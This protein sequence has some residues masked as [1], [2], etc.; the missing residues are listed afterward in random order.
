MVCKINIVM[1]KGLNDHIIPDI[2]A[3]VKEAG[4]D[5]CNIM[6]LIPVKGTV[7]EHL[8]MV[9][10]TEIMETR[11][12]CE[13]VLPQMYHCRQCRADAIGT[14][15]EDI[16]YQFTGGNK[17][18]AIVE[19]RSGDGNTGGRLLFAVASK[20]GIAVDQHF[21]HVTAFHI[22]RYENGKVEFIEK[23]EVSQY[24]QG[25]QDCGISAGNAA[26]QRHEDILN[27]IIETVTGC[28]GVIAL[29]IGDEPLRR[30]REKGIQFYTTYTYAAEAVKE[31]AEKLIAEKERPK[32][33]V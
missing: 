12:K 15:D 7:F 22:Y 11:K 25:K 17:P 10:N 21:G 2:A 3:K 8:P 27:S 6:Q 4:A 18:G 31:F 9:S 13:A 28:A 19:N 33:N 16:S 14:L 32:E 26:V 1:L 20:N 5:I 23:R 30:L 24:C 29:R